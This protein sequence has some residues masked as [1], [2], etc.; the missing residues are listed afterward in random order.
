MEVEIFSIMNEKNCLDKTG[1]EK[2]NTTN[3][4][5]VKTDPKRCSIKIK[6]FHHHA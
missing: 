5:Y 2:D 1:Q 6:V 4:K 3:K